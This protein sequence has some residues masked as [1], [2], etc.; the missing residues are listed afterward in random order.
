MSQP[1]MLVVDDETGVRE[2][3]RLIFGKD[4]RL[5]E[6]KSS[7]EAVRRIRD[8]RPE[9][10]LLDILMP[11]CNGLDTLKQIK[12]LHPAGQVI[13]LT[14]LNTA[15]TAFT[16]KES[17]A[18]DYVTKPFDV[19]E[20]R[21]RVSRA[22]ERTQLS[23]ELERLKEE[24]ARKYGIENIVGKSK[25]ML[26][27]YKIVAMVAARK[28]TVLITGES[29]TGKELIARAIHFN[30]DR[31]AK[32]FVVINCA[33]LPDTL[34]ESELFGYEKGAFT[35]AHQRKVGHF[36]LAHGGTLCLD[37]IGELGIGTQAKFLRA[38]EME[39]FTR[40]GGTEEIKV[41]V[42]VI[43]A[44]NRDLE[45]LAGSGGFRRDLFYRLNVVSLQLPPLR[46]RREDILLL[47]DHFLKLKAKESAV[48]PRILA[49]EVI[50]CVMSYPWPGNV[51]ELENL[52]ERLTVLSP[53]ETVTLADL[54]EGMRF[55]DPTVSLKEKVLQGSSPLSDAV[56]EFEREM[57]LKALQKTGFNQ[58]KAASLLGTS[59]RVL[60]YRMEKLQITESDQ[61][62]QDTKLSG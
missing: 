21:L 35:N 49:P 14:A 22:L 28:S 6:A 39:T 45:K 34:I 53:H 26:D 19:D 7:E 46:E 30:S 42:R 8:E 55:R 16:A 41:D 60:R 13:M 1:C 51:R 15:R 12:T 25:A 31:R 18:F 3:I 4:F 43:A 10:V 17:G 44:S 38:V 48:A 61:N 50:D 62:L 20:L 57:I 29:G 47:L 2:S 23:S 24:V 59:R 54:P 56:D 5:C 9:V 40:L 33:A 37:E 52:V 32:P 58:T 11:G 36:E 27:I